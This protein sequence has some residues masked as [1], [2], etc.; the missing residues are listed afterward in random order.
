MAKA[1]YIFYKYGIRFGV[2]A[3]VSVA[4]QASHGD[5]DWVDFA[6]RS[7]VTCLVVAA[8]YPLESWLK[9]RSA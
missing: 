8:T 3:I 1:K 6:G 5:W 7:I 2:A 9:K 4:F